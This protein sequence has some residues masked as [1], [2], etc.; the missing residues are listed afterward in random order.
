MW[1]I[2]LPSARTH[3]VFYHLFQGTSIT[4]NKEAICISCHMITYLIGFISFM[5]E[6]PQRIREQG[7][8][9][10][11]I[12]SKQKGEDVT[13]DTFF[14]FFFF[15]WP[16]A[17]PRANNIKFLWAF[18]LRVARADHGNCWDIKFIFDI[19]AISS[20]DTVSVVLVRRFCSGKHIIIF[21][22]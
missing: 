14:F 19:P 15:L 2:L 4:K 1:Q 3:H 10:E 12:T 13:W 6:N 11:N 7:C 16:T 20:A 22:L 5:R 8:E 17:Q 21:I 18:D 9:E